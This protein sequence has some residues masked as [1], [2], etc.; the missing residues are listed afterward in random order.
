[1]ITD[2]KRYEKNT[3]AFSIAEVEAVHGKSVVI[4]G[5][6]GLG[7]Y[8]AMTLARFGVG[9]L[10]LIDGDVFD[11]SNLNR[12]LFCTEG[13]LGK[14][15]ALEAKE[16]LALVNS[17]VR[18]TAIV[19]RLDEGNCGRLLAGHDAAVDCLDNVPA[20]LTLESGCEEAGI[21]LIHGAIGGFF[22]QV[23][24]V[25]PGDGTLHTLYAGHESRSS[26]SQAGNPP[27]TPQMVASVQ[28]SEVLKLLAGKE[29]LLR[30]KLL[31][32]DLSNN[33][34]HTVELA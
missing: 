11:T 27:F 28:C 34:F 1:M 19:E 4:V 8:V 26:S 18:V 31:L 2:F 24:C 12:Q 33:A 25:F 13:N 20:R 15:K 14:S 23:S 10:T 3:N 7:G 32:M 9:R 17:D 16:A 29:G 22:G 21:P 6:G 5:C 30:K